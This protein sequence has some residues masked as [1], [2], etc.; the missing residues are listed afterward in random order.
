MKIL[1]VASRWD[2]GEP[3]RGLSFEHLNFYDCLE[4][5]GHELNYFDYVA[6]TQE[7][8]LERMNQRLLQT[9]RELKPHLLFA[10]VQGLD[11]QPSVFQ[12]ISE[13]GV[14]QTFHWFCDDHF[15][16]EKFS[17]HLSPAFNWVATTASC[18]LPKY[19]RIGYDHV[20]KT[21]W[22]CNHF[23]YRR[24]G[25]PL[26]YDVS[27]VGRVFR[28][29]PAL[30]ERLRGAGLNVMVRGHGWPEGRATQEEMIRIFNQSRIN[31]NLSAPAKHV[32]WFKRLLGREQPPHQIKGR[33]F[34]V[35][36]CGGFLLTDHADNLEE[37]Y[38]PGKEIVLFENFKDLVDK[39]H[40]Y[41]GHETERTAIAEA[42]Y[43]RTL[44][45]HTYE[46]R[47]KQIFQRLGFPE[48]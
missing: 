28:D 27:F 43:Q 5:L 48:T 46:L 34:E 20:I 32:N 13:G 45:E 17:Q 10:C 2:Y 44:R 29:R 7:L 24:L 16:F 22:A 35:P 8:G 15:R 25:L 19:R 21:Q 39:V 9:A 30:I 1:Y 26:K 40:Y 36:G 11:V 37:Y 42:G 41:L 31:L 3:E 12:S 4:H 38:A 33:N 18:A 14:T 23:L 47:F 6:L